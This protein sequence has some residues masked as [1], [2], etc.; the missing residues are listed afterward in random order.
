MGRQLLVS[1][2]ATGVLADVGGGRFR[3]VGTVVSHVPRCAGVEQGTDRDVLQFTDAA[4]FP[5]TMYW[6]GLP[7][8]GDYGWNN[9]APEPANTYIRR[10]WNGSLE[11][12]AVLLDRYDFTQD[13]AFARDTLV[14]LAD[15]LIAFLDQYWQQRDA[16]GKIRLEPASLETWHVAVNPLPEIA[17]FRFLLPRLLA[18]PDSVTTEAQR[19]RWR[20]LLG[21][22]PPI[23]VAEVNGQKVL[24]PAESFSHKSNSE[25][26]ELYAV[27][28][29]RLYGV[30]VQTS[31]WPA[32]RTSR[33][34]RHNHGWCQ[35][36]IQAACLGL[37]DE[38]AR[39]VSAAPRRSIAPIASQSCGGR[40]SI[41]FPT[42]TTATTS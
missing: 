30:A 31:T 38:A 17:G 14:P 12:I 6:W 10:Y 4:Q 18:L 1:E 21:E 27:F 25:N 23:P 9:A 29:Y 11:L 5:E 8:N 3:D 32:R 28:P 13:A 2:H 15:P 42:K 20:R 33:G 41:G 34:H 19:A 22:L 7:N 37:G 16:N 40:T 35:D 24:R 39:L 26:T 36:S